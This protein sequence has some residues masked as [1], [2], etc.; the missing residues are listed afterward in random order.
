MTEELYSIIKSNPIVIETLFH[1]NKYEI[2]II[3]EKKRIIIKSSSLN[4]IYEYLPIL[5]DLFNDLFKYN[6][7][8]SYLIT[9]IF[10][11]NCI[12]YE[13]KLN[14]HP[15]FENF[16]YIYNFSFYINLSL[17][18]S[19]KNKIN[20][21]LKTNKINIDDINPLNQTIIH[22]I[23]NYL[24]NDHIKYIKKDILEKEL[25]PL[26]SNINPH[27]FELNII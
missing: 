2:N 24:E 3:N 20:I 13:I 16:N 12:I 7:D 22:I 27:S 9:E 21:Q 14:N 15:I 18:K 6:N 4:D 26:L 5:K 25:K 1:L 17:D 23:T 10:E 8:I 11:N 19:N